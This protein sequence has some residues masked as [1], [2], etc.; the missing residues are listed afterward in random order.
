[1][2][3]VTLKVD[4]LV[5][6]KSH[7]KSLEDRITKSLSHKWNGAYRVETFLTPNTVLISYVNDPNL[8]KRSRV[9]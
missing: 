4:D 7:F 1:M 5:L 6:I 8:K 3:P 9:T 2:R